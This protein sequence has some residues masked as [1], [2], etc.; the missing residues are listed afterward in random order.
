[1]ALVVAFLAYLEGRYGRPRPETTRRAGN[2]SVSASTRMARRGYADGDAEKREE[3][4][5]I[6]RSAS[7]TPPSDNALCAE[8]PGGWGGHARGAP[9]HC[10]APAASAFSPGTAKLPASRRVGPSG[11]RV[12]C[13][14][15]YKDGPAGSSHARANRTVPG[16]LRGYVGRRSVRLGA[17]SEVTGTSGLSGST[18]AW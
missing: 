12:H 6:P 15:V 17:A 4:R 3:R 11:C 9:C 10:H 13:G 2:I 7:D 5:P 8:P 16:R 1:M 18:R 14:A